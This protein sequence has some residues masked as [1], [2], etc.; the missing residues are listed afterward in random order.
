MSRRIWQLSAVAASTANS[1]ARRFSTGNAPGQAQAHRADVGVRRIAEAG[2]AAA[3]NLGARQELDVD[4]QS[5]DRLVPGL[6]RDRSFRRGGHVLIIV[7]SA[8]DQALRGKL[9][10]AVEICT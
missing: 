5:D 4:F 1:T 3:E 2:R 9:G 10:N 8:A 6:R 7:A